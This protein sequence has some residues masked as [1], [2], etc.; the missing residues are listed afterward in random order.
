MAEIT[1][2][3]V[4]SL[5]EKTGAGMMDCKKALSATD[6]I[7]EDSIDW[8]RKNGLASAQKKSGRTAAEG[9]V[10]ACSGGK[11]GA[12]IEINSETDFVARNEKFQDFVAASAK[13]ALQQAGNLTAILES[14]YPDTDKDFQAQLTENIATIGE[15]M[16][17]RRAAYLKVDS[18]VVIHYIHSAL[19]DN[20]GKIA[21]LVALE[22]TANADKL[23]EIAYKIAMHVAAARPQFL[24]IDSV[25]PVVLERERNILAEQARASGKSEEIIGKMVEGRLRKYYEESVLLEQIFVM[26]NESKIGTMLAQ[27][28]KEIGADI[29]LSAFERYQLGEGIE[30][31]ESDF[32]SE[33]ANA[34]KN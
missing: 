18:G 31:E 17:L 15:N 32:A 1:A 3:L 4:K 10:A 12:V 21:V 26:D 16:S 28:S 24:S 7:L 9:L 13:I 23:R 29:T 30:K 22:S 11:A 19:R 5:R 25:D 2:T 33:V 34:A 14:P 27:F 8:L 20:M 6:G